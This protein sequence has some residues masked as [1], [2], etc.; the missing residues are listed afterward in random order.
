MTGTNITQRVE[1]LCADRRIDDAAK[2]LVGKAETGDADALFTLALWRV[3][4]NFIRR[5]LVA[6]RRY[7]EASAR[8][9]RSDA[10]YFHALFLANGT[11]GPPDWAKAR[12]RIE[13]LGSSHSLSAA[14]SSLLAAMDLDALGNPRQDR[15]GYRLS[16]SPDIVACEH[17][18]SESECDYL[19]SRS[20]DR[21]KPSMVVDPS[22]GGFIPHPIR[23]SEGATFG[24][25][26]EDL[27]VNAINRR[28]ASFSA[29]AVEQGE[30]LQILRYPPG[31]EYRPH[32]DALPAT[33]NQRILTMIVYLN[34]RYEGGET[35][36]LATDLPFKGRK[37]DALLFRNVTPSGSPDPTARHAGLPVRSGTKLIASR[38]IRQKPF[39]FP[40]PV[41]VTGDRFP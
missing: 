35:H 22:T 2:L 23:R 37:G 16:D 12:A 9:G 21:L 32:M 36:F 41:P 26:D 5:D 20:E 4:G 11:G 27:A 33:D 7:M 3:F 34:D 19:K 31:G 39:Q 28:I 40:P 30:A 17:F 8:A 1:R 38:W 24:V 10:A 14:Q 29:T 25:F 6:A 18:L 13:Q 15:E